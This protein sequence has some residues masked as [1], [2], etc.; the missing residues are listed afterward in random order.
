M[1]AGLIGLRKMMIN[2]SGNP[3]GEMNGVPYH[4]GPSASDVK[5]QHPIADE[6]MPMIIQQ[7]FSFD[8]ADT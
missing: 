8:K 5:T 4:S 6:S 7:R 3:S 1:L 2:V